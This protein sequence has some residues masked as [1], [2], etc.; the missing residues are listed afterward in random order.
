MIPVTWV[1][2][3]GV[4]AERAGC[5]HQLSLGTGASPISS[6][7]RPAFQV[8]GNTSREKITLRNT[9]IFSLPRR[10]LSPC[11]FLS[12]HTFGRPNHSDTLFPGFKKKRWTK[13]LRLPGGAKVARSL[14]GSSSSFWQRGEGVAVKRNHLV[15]G[16]GDHRFGARGHFWAGSPGWLQFSTGKAEGGLCQQRVTLQGCVVVGAFFLRQGKVL[17]L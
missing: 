14:W 3:P 1:A 15:S 12:A 4:E 16:F 13:N 5:S 11:Q 17:L 9:E 8:S 10:P 7:A 6:S 2:R